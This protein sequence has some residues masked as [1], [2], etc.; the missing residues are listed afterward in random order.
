MSLE[1]EKLNWEF[2]FYIPGASGWRGSPKNCSI[3]VYVYYLIVQ[4]FNTNNTEFSYTSKAVKK[5]N[6]REI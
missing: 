4:T 5:W 3:L 6:N 1:T 2:R